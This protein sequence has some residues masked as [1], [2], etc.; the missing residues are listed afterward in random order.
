MSPRMAN[1]LLVVPDALHRLLDVQKSINKM[2]VPLQTLV[3]VHLRVGQINGRTVLIT[4]NARERAE[5][6]ET[7]DRHPMVATWREASC[8]SDAERAAL[9][10]A[11]AVTRLPDREDP[12]PDEVWDEAARHYNE[13]ELGSLVMLIGLVNL[14]NRINVATKQ[15]PVDW[16]VSPDAW[17][18]MTKRLESQ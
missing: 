7:D 2:G 17:T 10:L 1:P 16:R 4:A 15:E 9:A 12:V 8:F 5:A 6:G 11:E 14:W 3:L 13:Q 18:P